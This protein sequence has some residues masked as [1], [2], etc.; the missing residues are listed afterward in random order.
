MP[1]IS[2]LVKKGTA[3]L[4]TEATFLLVT[5]STFAQGSGANFGPPKGSVGADV[6]AEA[7]PQLIVN[8]IFALA[9]FLAVVYLMYGGIRWM[10][11]RGDKVAVESARKHVISAVIGLV[12]VA[13]TFFI[14]NVVFNILGADNPLKE[15]FK[16]PTLKNVKP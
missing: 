8:L 13:G 3:F 10:T 11:S 2:S 4:L 1:R 15:G 6:D 7:I 16:L 9:I 12:V 5:T 14:L